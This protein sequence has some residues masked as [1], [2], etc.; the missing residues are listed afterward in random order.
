MDKEI[1]ERLL[2]K[3]VEGKLSAAEKI[4]LQQAYDQL[5]SEEIAAGVD[6]PALGPDEAK[7][8]VIQQKIYARINKQL[9]YSFHFRT[10]LKVAAAVAIVLLGPLLFSR[11]N[12]TDQVDYVEVAATQSSKIVKL[13][14]GTNIILGPHST[15]KYPRDF[16]AKDRNVFLTGNATFKVK[17]NGKRFIVN[18]GDV[19]TEVLGTFFNV[20]TVPES[21]QTKVAL[22]EGKVRMSYKNRGNTI[23]KPGDE[24]NCNLKSA[25]VNIRHDENIQSNN[26]KLDFKNTDLTEAVQQISIM[27]GIKLSV[28]QSVDKDLKITGTIYYRSPKET[29]KE[30]AFPF[31]LIVKQINESTYELM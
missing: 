15:L 22:F 23:L 1:F 31:G 2:Q 6:D 28:A 9:K 18:S 14:D 29:L 21:Q 16:E 20:V 3:Q 12:H 30:I 4:Q 19:K 17:H 8:L 11:L 24:W 7:E 26:L 5:F 27:Y 10:F 13:N 25:V